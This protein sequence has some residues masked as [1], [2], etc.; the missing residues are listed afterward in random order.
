VVELN[1]AVVVAE[2]QGRAAGLEI[3]DRVPLADYRHLHAIR[4]EL[5]RPCA[6]STWPGW[7]LTTRRPSAP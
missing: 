6:A 1:R 4:A 5:Q 3:V 7:G 2:A